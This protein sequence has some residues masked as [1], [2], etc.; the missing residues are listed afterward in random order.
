MS[1]ISEINEKGRDVSDESIEADFSDE[2]DSNYESYL[3]EGKKSE[4]TDTVENY[5]DTDEEN[6]IDNLDEELDRK[7]DEYIS[8]GKTDIGEEKER[9]IEDSG[10]SQ[11][12]VEKI[13]SDEQYDIYKNAE[14]HEEEVNGRKCLVKDIDYDYIDEKTGMT[15]KELME[16]GRSPI[17][18]KTGE[19]IELHHMGQ[20]YDSPFAELDENSEHG[21]GNHKILHPKT[22]NSWRNNEE[23][24]NQYQIDRKEHWK[25]RSTE[26]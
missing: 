25:Q 16:K 4:N 23:L 12:I 26:A 24:K 22:D 11:D 9:Y 13:D 3:Q 15:N 19:K 6:E 20:D 21:D 14:L 2:L 18:S 5:D 8:S 10:W 1:E 17:D 7:Y